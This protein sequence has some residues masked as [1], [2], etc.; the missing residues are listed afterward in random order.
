[1]QKIG[2]LTFHRSINYGA[3]M[4]CLS[5]SHYLTERFPDCRVEVIDYES[6]RM[7]DNYVPKLSLS[8]IRHPLIYNNKKKQYKSFLNVLKFLPLSDK[9]FVFDGNNPEFSAHISNNY[10]IV[11]VGSDAVFNW[12]KRGFPNPYIMQFD[13]VKKLSYAASAYGMS[14]DAITPEQIEA[15]GK[16]LETFEF[17]GVRD[18]Y[19][20]DLVKSA[21]KKLSPTFTCDPTVFLDLNYVLKLLGHTKESYK[22]Y[23][24]Q[25]YKLPKNKKLVGVMESNSDL[26]NALKQKYSS[27]Y[28]FVGLYTH[29]KNID[30][31]IANI[32]PLEWSLIFGLF[33]FTITNYFHG[34]LLSLRNHTPV[35]SFDRT[36]FSKTNEG[37]IHDVMRRMDLLDCYFQGK[38]DLQVAMNKVEHITKNRDEYVKKIANNLNVLQSSRDEFEKYLEKLLYRI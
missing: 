28:H 2:I 21:N 1:M 24:Y 37:K 11:I 25:K 15:F 8:Y 23:I 10:D 14:K 26:V 32:N 6:R 19:T 38:Y 36:E 9:Y 22:D 30:T 3:Y 4:Q 16:S 33:N 5:L 18:N 35:L 29:T 17:I 27:E 34:T 31:F 13:N 7:H 20:N 12:I